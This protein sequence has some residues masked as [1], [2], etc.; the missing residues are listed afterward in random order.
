MPV[1]VLVAMLGIAG[2][3]LFTQK[4]PTDMDLSYKCFRHTA[5]KVHD[6]LGNTII[7]G[8]DAAPAQYL[9]RG[10]ICDNG[11]LLPR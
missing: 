3:M 2:A 9:N 10:I 4:G 1:L 7:I 6:D 5:Q 11:E 8:V